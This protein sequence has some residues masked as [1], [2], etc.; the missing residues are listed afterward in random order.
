MF[1]VGIIGVG[2]IGST[3]AHLLASNPA[4]SLHLYDKNLQSTQGKTLD[5]VQ[6]RL[7]GQA[8]SPI[9]VVDKAEDLCACD[10]IVITAGKARQP[11]MDRNA[12]LLFNQTLMV[13]LAT[14]LKKAKGLVLIV[15]NPVDIMAAQFFHTSQWA[16]HRVIAMAG[17][18]DS[19]RFRHAL[20]RH[21]GCCPQDVEGMV[22]GAH[23][24]GMLPVKSSVRIK[25]QALDPNFSK[26]DWATIVTQTQ[27]GGKE[28][29]D[30]LGTGSAFYAPA[31]C[32]KVM[33][34]AIAFDQKRLLSCGMYAQDVYGINDV[35]L[36]LPI[37]LGRTGIENVCPLAL[38]REEES[39]LHASVDM[40]QK[41]WLTHRIDAN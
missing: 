9:T 28:I 18:L 4:F 6:S 32:L 35:F 26:T 37:I 12:L 2:N 17:L 16:P 5:L 24:D 29:V 15:T 14:S 30:L 33:I 23:N 3:L 1:S 36:S 41:T 40:L 25:G 39:Q 22:I 10:V 31:H 38:D 27:Q 11:G 19:L 21:F 7:L 13:E 20:M 8:H 34:E